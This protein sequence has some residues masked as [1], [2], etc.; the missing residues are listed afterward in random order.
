M[1]A[2]AARRAGLASSWAAKN[3]GLLG[4]DAE[5]DG[6]GRR[7][8]LRSGPLQTTAARPARCTEA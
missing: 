3:A 7:A 2:A 5:R 4:A 6:S 1:Q 8:P